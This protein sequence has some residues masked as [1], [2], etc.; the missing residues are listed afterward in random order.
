M[1]KGEREEQ[2]GERKFTSKHVDERSNRAESGTACLEGDVDERESEFDR[3]PRG[4]AEWVHEGGED[5]HDL[6]SRRR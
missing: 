1:G 3:V 2:R 6:C 4:G 5:G